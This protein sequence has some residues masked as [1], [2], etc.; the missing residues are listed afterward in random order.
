M[1]LG[2]GCYAM[3]RLLDTTLGRSQNNTKT[4]RGIESLYNM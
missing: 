4:V 2:K 1:L 3:T